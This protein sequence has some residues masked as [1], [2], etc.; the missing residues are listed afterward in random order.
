MANLADDTE[1]LK[2]NF[3]FRGFF[4]KRGYYNLER[5]TPEEYRKSRFVSGESSQRIWLT[6]A[7]LF[8]SQAN[9]REVL[10]PSANSRLDQAFG[11]FVPSLPN[12]PVMIE[13]YASAGT[14]AERYG[15]AQQRASIVCEYLKARFQLKPELLGIMPLGETPPP[16][17]GRDTWDG[18]SLV[19]LK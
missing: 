7:E 1:A 12:R 5:L 11:T 9:G 8:S 15:T 4:K 3:F 13:G 16:G 19:L 17:S 18:V 2:R 14:P 6:S 10:S